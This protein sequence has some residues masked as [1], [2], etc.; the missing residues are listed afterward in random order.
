MKSQSNHLL[1]KIIRYASY[2]QAEISLSTVYVDNDG[3]IQMTFADP[4]GM[5]SG[6]IAGELYAID[7]NENEYAIDVKS[8]GMTDE[9]SLKD[10]IISKIEKLS[11]DGCTIF[12]KFNLDIPFIPFDI[13]PS[14]CC[15]ER[16]KIFLDVNYSHLER[17]DLRG[18]TYLIAL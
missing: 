1:D 13:W 2:D 17:C 5:L 9:N 14:D 18:S 4:S 15:I 3:N 7:K 8:N 10:Q 6:D 12:I 16:V 11:M